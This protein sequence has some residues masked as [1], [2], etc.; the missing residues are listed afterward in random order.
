[1]K[2]LGEEDSHPLFYLS[3]ICVNLFFLS[4]TIS[5]VKF[6]K[7][8]EERK[9]EWKYLPGIQIFTILINCMFWTVSG[10]SSEENNMWL[11]NVIG[12]I[13]ALIFVFFY[14]KSAFSGKFKE[15][16]I[17]LFNVCNILFQLGWGSFYL[18]NKL[19]GKTNDST[20]Q[21]GHY[22]AMVF[23]ILMYASVFQNVYFTYKTK[24]YTKLP[25]IEALIGLVSNICWIAYSFIQK[26]K[27]NS[28]L[29]ILIPNSVSLVILIVFIIYYCVLRFSK[30]G[31][32]TVSNEALI[33]D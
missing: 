11:V 13:I 23:N 26:D 18:M 16:F 27:G 25:I 1:M 22:C 4:P 6:Y 3:T 17:Y 10:I 28:Y 32:Q 33:K 31:V 5:F 9:E 30:K 12:L 2:L 19:K 14:W 21:F 8:K 24:D 20:L 7:M 29:Q 15:Y